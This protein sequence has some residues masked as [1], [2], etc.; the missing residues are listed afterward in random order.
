MPVPKITLLGKRYV[1][2][3]EAEYRQLKR[4]VAS[5]QAT[6]KKRIPSVEDLADIAEIKRIKAD[7]TQKLIPWSEAKKRLR[8][9]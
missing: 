6:R 9:L 7:P 5:A 3:P 1:V 8:R 4:S 2:I